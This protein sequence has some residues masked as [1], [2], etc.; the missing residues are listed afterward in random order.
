MV[1][2]SISLGSA[3]GESGFSGFVSLAIGGL[4]P[5]CSKRKPLDPDC[6][7]RGTRGID[8]QVVGL[9]DRFEGTVP[10]FGRDS[11]NFGSKC[12]CVR[13]KQSIG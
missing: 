3:S 1:Q 8:S 13:S 9:M 11:H 2:D 4:L 12:G 7:N 5:I 6:L 10:N